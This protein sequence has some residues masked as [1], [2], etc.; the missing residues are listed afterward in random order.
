MVGNFNWFDSI[1]HQSIIEMN[2]LL[3]ILFSLYRWF[4]LRITFLMLS[5]LLFEGI[6]DDYKI[7]RSKVIKVKY[8]W[9]CQNWFK[10]ILFQLNFSEYPSKYFWNIEY[11]ASLLPH[12]FHYTLS[13]QNIHCLISLSIVNY[14]IKKE[15]SHRVES[16]FNWFDFIFSSL[17]Y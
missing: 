10:I 2:F 15:S 13:T 8:F 16:T 5:P 6:D 1:F 12:P 4:I 7:Q 14:L 17:Y 9:R 3:I 11:N